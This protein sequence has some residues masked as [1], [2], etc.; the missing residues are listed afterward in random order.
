MSA[1]GR[2]ARRSHPTRGR[3]PCCSAASG[4]ARCSCS[5]RCSSRD[6]RSR[7]SPTPRA[8]GTTRGRGSRSGCA[9]TL[10]SV[11]VPFTSTETADGVASVA[12]LQVA[13]GALTIA[14]LVLA[15]RAGREQ[16]RGLGTA[17]GRRRARRARRSGSAS[18]SRCSWRRSPSRSAS[19]SSASTGSQ[20][21]LWLAFALPLWWP[22]PPGPSA[23]SPAPATQLEGAPSWAARC[24]A[25]RAGRRHGLLVGARAVVRRVPARWRRSPPGRPAPTRGSSVETGGSGAATVIQ[26][27][28]LLPNQSAMILADL[29]GRDR[30][31]VGR[32]RCRRGVGSRPACG[33]RA[34][35]GRSSPPTWVRTGPAPR[36]PS[37]FAVF[38]LIPALACVL[39]GRAA[40]AGTTARWASASSEARS[41]GVVFA[42]L[43]G[44]RGVGRDARGARLGERARRL[45][46]ARHRRCSR[47]PRSRSRG[48]SLGGLVGAAIPWPGRVSA[49]S[50]PR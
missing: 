31:A 22:D 14:V 10:A 19:R 25:A 45:G 40:A 23:A 11:R 46:V 6:R 48:A 4:A 1:G 47:R 38:L 37:W 21:V 18:R 35:R 49:A 36:S 44:A 33:R 15:F 24:A 17:T 41:A 13:M 50:G 2:S 5:C 12:T 42:G 16:A 8:A 26:H 29:D 30:G 3:A 7:G 27:A 28:V 9:E 39:G 43:C 20:P 34:R 32:R